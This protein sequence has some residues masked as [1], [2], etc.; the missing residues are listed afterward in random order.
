MNKCKNCNIE[1]YNPKFC[2]RSCSATFNNKGVNR[3][4]NKHLHKEK[5]NCFNCGKITNNKKFCSLKCSYEYPKR[6]NIRKW[7]NNKISGLSPNGKKIQ[8]FIK[9]YLIEKYGDKCQL[10]NWSEIH[11]ITKKVP[12]QLDHIDGNFRNCRLEN[13]RLL[14]PNCHSLTETFGALNIKNGFNASER[15]YTI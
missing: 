1:T 14:Y 4:V 3:H 8:S 6:E 13:V 7:L 10:C 2:S 9:F 15:R 12:I 11:P 5:N